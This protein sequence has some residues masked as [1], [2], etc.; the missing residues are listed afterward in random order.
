MLTGFCVCANICNTPKLNE[1]SVLKA[2]SFEET[3][4]NSLAQRARDLSAADV[5]AVRY[6]G[7]SGE[8]SPACSPSGAVVQLE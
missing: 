1:L 7:I 8:I 3:N 5:I 6:C 4:R 2:L